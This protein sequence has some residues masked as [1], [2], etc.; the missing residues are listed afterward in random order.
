MRVGSQRAQ[1]NAKLGSDVVPNCRQMLSG[2]YPYDRASRQDVNLNDFGRLFGPGGVLDGF[3]N[4]Q[5]R[6]FVDTARRTWRW[7]PGFSGSAGTLR[8]FQRAQRIRERRDDECQQESQRERA[9]RPTTNPGKRC[10]H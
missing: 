4:A 3:F 2:R 8:Q 1:I 9:V 5:L 10:D 6:P 7:R